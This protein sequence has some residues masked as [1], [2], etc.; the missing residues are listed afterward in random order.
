MADKFNPITDLQ[1]TDPFNVPVGESSEEI[2]SIRVKLVVTRNKTAELVNIL[3]KKNISFN[4]DIDT[5]RELNRRLMRTIPRIPILRGD[6]STQTNRLQDISKKKGQFD[7]DVMTS[8]TTKEPS[9]NIVGR[10]LNFAVDIVTIFLGGR[11]IKGILKK[12][13]LNW[14]L[15]NKIFQQRIKTLERIFNKPSFTKPNQVPIKQPNKIF[16]IPLSREQI[17]LKNIKN[18]LREA[19]SKTGIFNKKIK[20]NRE[21]FFNRGNVKNSQFT[22][23]ENLLQKLKQR[24]VRTIKNIYGTTDKNIKNLQEYLKQKK[25]NPDLQL[26][27]FFKKNQ[28]PV[29]GGA[30]SGGKPKNFI[31]NTTENM[32][33]YGDKNLKSF[34]IDGFSSNDIARGLNRDTNT[35]RDIYIVDDDFTI[36]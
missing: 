6:A 33:K 18:T 31:E 30:Q 8:T 9:T 20:V 26:D 11:I 24:S 29:G 3:K 12:L 4:K 28:K 21:S 13:G 19:E 7:I 2:E 15:K 10:I 1:P 5:I 23:P 35:I 34:N 36:T 16:N 14:L 22:G 32:R 25:K 17:R 27:D